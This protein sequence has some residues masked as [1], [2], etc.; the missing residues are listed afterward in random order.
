MK[1]REIEKIAKDIRKSTGRS[2]KYKQSDYI[3]WKIKDGYFFCLDTSLYYNTKTHW[4]YPELCVKPIYI[5]D[6]YWKIIYPHREMKLP[7]S[8]RGNGILSHLKENIWKE[9]TPEILNT[10]FKV[11]EFEQIISDIFLK[12][13]QEISAFLRKYPHP[14]LFG[15]FLAEN[16]GGCALNNIL[17]L[18]NQ[19]GF[20]EAAQLTKERIAANRGVTNV[21]VISEG[22]NRQEK[23]EFEFILEYCQT[24]ITDSI[25]S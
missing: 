22:E 6:L 7:D 17:I 14:D 21:Y 10:K 24:K 23:N 4:M 3:N 15:D 11:E 16:G 2:Y 5:D 13:E 18:I 19:G 25:K 8:R 9:K 12:A 20:A 1:G